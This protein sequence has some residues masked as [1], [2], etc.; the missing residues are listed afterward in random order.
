[1]NSTSQEAVTTVSVVITET[2]SNTVAIATSTAETVSW[3]GSF[4]GFIGSLFGV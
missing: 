2:A 4:I 3:W 1:M